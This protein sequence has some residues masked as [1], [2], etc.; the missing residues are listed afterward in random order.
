MANVND[1][2]TKNTLL[3]TLISQISTGGKI[4]IEELSMALLPVIP[5][6][7]FTKFAASKH[8]NL[9]KLREHYAHKFAI[10]F[11]LK[12]FKDEIK[13]ENQQGIV[14]ATFKDLAVHNPANS[15]D[16]R[17]GGEKHP[18]PFWDSITS[19]FSPRK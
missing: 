18:L 1:T 8:N 14:E 19:F 9:F 5:A 16:N 6:I 2:A 4:E 15:I 13:P 10:S 17:D 11:S 12:G 3:S 7:V